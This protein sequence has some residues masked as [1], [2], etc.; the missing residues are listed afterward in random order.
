MQLRAVF[1]TQSEATFAVTSACN[2]YGV[3]AA[4]LIV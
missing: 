2:P 1:F 4:R 3:V